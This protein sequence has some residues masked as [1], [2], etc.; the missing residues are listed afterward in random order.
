[1]ARWGQFLLFHGKLSRWKFR[2]LFQ[3]LNLHLVFIFFSIPV[4]IKT[5]PNSAGTLLN[6]SALT[7]SAISKGLENHRC[8]LEWGKSQIL[9]QVKRDFTTFSSFKHLVSLLFHECRYRAYK[10][11]QI[12][13][14][15]ICTR[16]TGREVW[17]R[18]GKAPNMA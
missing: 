13:R 16:M 11:R 7:S 15:L 14:R 9:S 12:K 18:K 1:M 5:L 3:V 4:K 17:K 10:I 2:N 8:W 6:R